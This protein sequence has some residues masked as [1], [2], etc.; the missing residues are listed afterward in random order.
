MTFFILL[1][2][3]SELLFL[4]YEKSGAYSFIDYIL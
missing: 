3:Q 1:Q 2:M 4:Q